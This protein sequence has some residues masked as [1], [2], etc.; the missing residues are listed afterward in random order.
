METI[1]KNG[2][3]ITA[4]ENY[5]ADI[6]IQDGKIVE[7]AKKIDHSENANIIDAQGKYVF[8]GIID[9]HVHLALPMAG[10][11]SSDDFVNGTKAAACGGVTTILDFSTQLKGHGLLESIQKHREEADKKVCIDYSFHAGIT[12]WKLARKEIE[13]AFAAGISSFKMFMAYRNRNLMSED[14]DIFC[15]LEETNKY[16]GV[17]SVHAESAIILEHL[18]DRYHTPENCAKHGVWAHVLSRP[19]VVEVEAIERAIH[20]AELSGGTLY[21]VHTSTGDG[22]KA[23]HRGRKRGVK[24]YGETCTQ[25]LL[26]D[27]SVFQRPDGYLYTSCPQI[28]SKANQEQLWKNLQNGDFQVLAT[29]HCPFTKTQKDLWQGDFT[30]LPFG[31]PGVETL[32][33]TMYTACV[34]SGKIPL[35]RLIALL[36]YNPAKIYG[37]YPR[38]G[39]IAIGSDGDLVIFD[40]QYKV[41]LDYHNLQTNCDWSPYQGMSLTG[42][43]VLTI[44]RGEVVAKEGKFVGK[45]GHGQFISRGPCQHI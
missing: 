16:G 8:P 21:I 28:K 17:I 20:W 37:L 23:I 9:A 1:I 12:D 10:T 45:V 40:P 11:I 34:G 29:D 41:T 24:V 4:S 18:I 35:Q 15:A 13:Q 22:A 43:P 38:K 39:T 44:S 26:L 7:I 30:K 27:N 3:I 14:D 42:Y 32:L 33:T 36:C 2:T 19:D 31:L 5:V 6:R 25:Y